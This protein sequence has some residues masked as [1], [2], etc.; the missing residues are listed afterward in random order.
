MLS[1]CY[2]AFD[3]IQLGYKMNALRTLSKK[4]FL[5]Y[6][7]L[8]YSHLLFATNLMAKGKGKLNAIARASA[9]VSADPILER[10]RGYQME[11]FQESLRRNIIVA[12]RT[13]QFT[14]TEINSDQ[15]IMSRWIP[16]LGRR[17]CNL[18]PL[19]SLPWQR[20]I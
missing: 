19:S 1:L 20:Q 10:T 9:P 15:N 5:H 2:P 18:I 3:R 6:Y 14:P 12:V 16:G 17:I 11:M 4:V 13:S 7:R 8:S